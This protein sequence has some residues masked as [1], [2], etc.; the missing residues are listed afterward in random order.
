M[1]RKALKEPIEPKKECE[2]PISAYIWFQLHNNIHVELTSV[3]HKHIL[4]LIRLHIFSVAECPNTRTSTQGSRSLKRKLSSPM[5]NEIQ[6]PERS[7]ARRQLDEAYDLL[8]SIT[9]R[10]RSVQRD[11][12]DLYGELLAKK[13]RKMGESMR[14]SV[15]NEIDNLVYRAKRKFEIIQ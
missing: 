11:E 2:D 9:E 7:E 15:M 6:V 12:C 10:S 5:R 1:E 4:K 14:E 3:E 8:N 13:L